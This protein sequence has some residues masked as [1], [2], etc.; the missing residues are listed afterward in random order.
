LGV[1]NVSEPKAP[2]DKAVDKDEKATRKAGVPPARTEPV[3]DG[4]AIAELGDAI[5]GPA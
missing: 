4:D 2:E 5:G 3:A 1:R